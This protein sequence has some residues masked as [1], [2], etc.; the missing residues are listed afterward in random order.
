MEAAVSVFEGSLGNVLEKL[1]LLAAECSRI[2]GVGKQIVFLSSELASMQALLRKV[3]AME[4][5]GPVDVQVKA[6]A[7]EVRE[8]AYDVE[9]CVDAFAHRQRL[10]LAGGTGST[11]GRQGQGGAGG[12][13]KE[14]FARCAR[15]LLTLRSWRQFASQ[16]DALKARAVEAG[17]R[18]ERYRLDDLA[19][20]SSSSSCS[21]VDPRLSAL[22]ADEDCLV[23]ID[24]P[25]DELVRWLLEPEGG[26]S[27]SS[28]PAAMH[29]PKAL[30]IVGFGGLGKTTLAN[31]V[32][33]KIE[34]HFV[35]KAFVSVSQKPNLKHILRDCLH[36]LCHDG[37]FVREICMWDEKEIITKTRE[38]IA[39]KR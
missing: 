5:D 10:A 38:Y 4:A 31:Q 32:F 25:R 21:G 30:S 22:F 26:A 7:R 13:V 35:C 9:D 29:H 3:A 17:E 36:Q 37:E 1:Q 19:G 20:A 12:G 33:R 18:R 23:G 28:A 16:I 6:W 15:F 2:R 11:Q 8:M 27:S 34:H 39:A 14:F 24:G